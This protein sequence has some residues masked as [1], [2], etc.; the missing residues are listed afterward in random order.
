[1]IV[2]LRGMRM[3]LR[4]RM[5]MSPKEWGTFLEKEWTSAWNQAN[6]TGVSMKGVCE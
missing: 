2:L 6:R 4:E 1:M 3:S 5:R